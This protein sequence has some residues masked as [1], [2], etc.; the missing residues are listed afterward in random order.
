MT[1]NPP[2]RDVLDSP[3]ESEGNLALGHALEVD[4]ARLQPY[5]RNPRHSPTPR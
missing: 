4:I 3:P 2:L 5:E 1:L